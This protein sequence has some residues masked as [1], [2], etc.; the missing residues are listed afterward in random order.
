[1]YL[2]VYICMLACMCVCLRFLSMS[3][4]HALHV[5]MH[6]TY[7]YHMMVCVCYSTHTIA[8]VVTLQSKGMY[9]RIRMYAFVCINVC[10]YYTFQSIRFLVC[11]ARTHASYDGLLQYT[12]NS[13]CCYTSKQRYVCMYS[14][15]CICMYECVCILYVSI[16]TF[17][18]MLCTY[19]CII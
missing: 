16:H 18:G 5:Y 11:F 6:H 15:I 19:T 12:Y 2:C 8:G 10:V 4:W 1:M 13:W 14:Y 9:V 7:M 17:L 3:C